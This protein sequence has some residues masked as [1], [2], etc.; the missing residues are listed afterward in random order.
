VTSAREDSERSVNEATG[1]RNNQ[2]PEAEA[3][4]YAMVA[5]A[6]AYRAERVNRAQGEAVRFLQLLSEYR[7]A[8]AVTRQRLLLEAMDDVL[9]SVDKF[10]MGGESGRGVLPVLPLSPL[11]SLPSAV[12]ADQAPASPASQGGET[13]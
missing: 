1:Y 4:A 10:V 5:Q 2:I 3:R 9:P 11:S 12:A 13:R 7:K 6:Q 8:P